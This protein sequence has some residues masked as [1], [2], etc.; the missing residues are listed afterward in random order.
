MKKI[1]LIIMVS[2]LS[3]CAVID[4]YFMAKFDNKEYALINKIRTVAQLSQEYCDHSPT[5]K[6]KYVELKELNTE[7]INY[8]QH[9][10]RNPE[11]NKLAKQM[12]ELIMQGGQAYGPNTSAIFCK[13]KLQQ[14]ERNAEKIQHVLGS[15]PR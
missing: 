6:T 9:I 5:I 14:I 10:P 2:L 4:A 11:A 1:A 8:T 13:M 15:K 3:G 7:F 12:G